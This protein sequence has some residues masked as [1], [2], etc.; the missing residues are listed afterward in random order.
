MKVDEIEQRFNDDISDRKAGK[1]IEIVGLK[2]HRDGAGTFCSFF[3]AILNF[4]SGDGIF[5]FLYGIAKGV[6]GSCVCSGEGQRKS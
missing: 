2:I 6:C 5:Y 1:S 4:V 3:Q